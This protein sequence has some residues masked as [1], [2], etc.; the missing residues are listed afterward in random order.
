M[1]E[2][3]DFDFVVYSKDWHP[4]DHISFVENVSKRPLHK[5][6]AVSNTKLYN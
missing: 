4:K 1:L 6:S 3:I 5:R 2:E